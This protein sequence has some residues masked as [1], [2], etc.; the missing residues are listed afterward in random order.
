MKK[1]ISTVIKNKLIIIFFL[2][3]NF[4]GLKSTAQVCLIGWIYYPGGPVNFDLPDNSSLT[5]PKGS[6]IHISLRTFY[7]GDVMTIQSSDS[8]ITYPVFSSGW[9]YLAYFKAGTVTLK[10]SS[11]FCPGSFVYL[12]LTI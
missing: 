7:I 2:L 3:F 1:N 11:Q 8:S 12:T 5:V 10:G 9:Y 4:F 6:N